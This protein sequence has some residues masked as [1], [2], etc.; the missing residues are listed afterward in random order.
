[1]MKPRLTT[2]RCRCVACGEFFNSVTS[3]D[4]H[5]TGTYSLH[6]FAETSEGR[7]CLSSNEMLS[8]GMSINSTGFWITESR[9]QRHDRKLMRDADVVA[10]PTTHE[11]G[12]EL[13]ESF[14]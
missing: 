9:A 2:V 5:R 14:A 13:C 8:R 4:R 6:P 3:F 1:M 11:D 7:R 10:L 12:A